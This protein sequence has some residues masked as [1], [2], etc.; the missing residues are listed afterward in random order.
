MYFK[1]YQIYL[2]PTKQNEKFLNVTKRDIFLQGKIRETIL[3]QSSLF[4]V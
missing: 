4:A 3:P 2:L 1:H